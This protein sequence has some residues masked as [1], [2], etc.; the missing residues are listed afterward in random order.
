MRLVPP[1]IINEH[2]VAEAI[3]MLDKVADRLEKKPKERD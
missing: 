1:L 2:H 3:K